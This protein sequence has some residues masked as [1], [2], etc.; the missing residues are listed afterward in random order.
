MVR[1]ASATVPPMIL[2]RL[3]RA[4]GCAA[5]CPGRDERGEGSGVWAMGGLSRL[6]LRACR[7][8]ERCAH[9]TTAATG[10]PPGDYIL[11]KPTLG[12]NHPFTE[13]I[14]NDVFIV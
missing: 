8:S 14:E 7:A 9:D 11:R 10:A 13:F 3:G 12:G 6:R 5:A 4:G 1:A 2:A